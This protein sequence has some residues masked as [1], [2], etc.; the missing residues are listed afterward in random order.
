MSATTRE[1]RLAEILALKD[2]EALDEAT[3]IYQVPFSDTY[4]FL[5]PT[6][7]G[8]VWATSVKGASRETA[9]EVAQ[10]TFEKASGFTAPA[11]DAVKV[12]EAPL[13][14]SPFAFDAFMIL[15][16]EV[17][18]FSAIEGDDFLKPM[19]FTVQPIHR[20]E[21]C[22][23]ET[24]AE[25][26][27]RLKHLRYNTI[28]RPPQ[29]AISGRYQ[30][31]D[32]KRSRNKQLGV[33]HYE[34]IAELI[35]DLPRDG[36][37]V[38]IDNFEHT[39]CIFRGER[40]KPE[41]T[42]TVGDVAEQTDTDG[43]LGIFDRLV[44]QGTEAGRADRAPWRKALDACHQQLA[45]AEEPELSEPAFEALVASLAPEQ[46][47]ALGWLMLADVA[48]WPQLSV[49]DA[50]SFF[51]PRSDSD[52]TASYPAREL[53]LAVEAFART[54]D[55]ASVWEKQRR[56]MQLARNPRWYWGEWLR[57]VVPQAISTPPDRA[58]RLAENALACTAATPER[59]NYE[60]G[61]LESG[62]II[63]SGVTPDIGGEE[64][65]D[66]GV[67]EEADPKSRDIRAT[68][69][70]KVPTDSYRMGYFLQTTVLAAFL[71]VDDG[72]YSSI[73]ITNLDTEEIWSR[74]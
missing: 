11:S 28:D 68:Y 44:T 38:E 25:A 74:S 63:V 47:E 12:A 73:Q 13:G 27:A 34:R 54:L 15:G 35:R 36:G 72:S 2:V 23:D 41:I 8:I 17:H 14:V 6:G 4:F 52:E 21:L 61:M 10:A 56:V 46:R 60:A 18:G 45:S 40:G 58:K 51:T 32:G 48:V 20:C 31:Q 66:F 26:R 64:F 5:R 29:P 65:V 19:T 62:E 57:R 42:V 16:P 1:E 39:R 3:T 33:T 67:V 49:S 55:T 53:A 30:T 50:E 24:V 22:G 69:R 9:I 70:P 37:T 59:W 71:D 7:D 43:A